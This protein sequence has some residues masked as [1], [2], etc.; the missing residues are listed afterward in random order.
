M[1]DGG[2]FSIAALLVSGYASFQSHSTSLSQNLDILDYYQPV[3][4]E[5]FTPE[6]SVITFISIL[7]VGP[8]IPPIHSRKGGFAGSLRTRYQPFTIP[9]NYNNPSE[10]YSNIETKEDSTENDDYHRKPIYQD[11]KKRTK[12]PIHKSNVPQDEI[13]QT[14]LLSTF[15]L[16]RCYTSDFTPSLR[17][18]SLLTIHSKLCKGPQGGP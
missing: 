9:E 7:V 8:N 16:Q 17:G 4:G 12:G 11:Y 6:F 5:S 13:A 14:H 10:T 3:P 2:L 15:P 18:E 1:A